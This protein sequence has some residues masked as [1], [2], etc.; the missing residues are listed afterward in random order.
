VD[1]GGLT[2]EEIAERRFSPVGRRGFDKAEV[3]A[4]LAEVAAA[5]RAALDKAEWAEDHVSFERL[6]AEAGALL[7]T[8]KEG[9]ES[10][11]R[12]AEEEAE[13]LRNSARE[14]AQEVR[15]RAKQEAAALVE[16]AT[17]EAER[18]AREAEVVARRLHN[19]TKRQCEQMVV[20]AE[21]RSKR[22]HAHQRA[23][24]NKINDMER[25]FRAFRAEMESS[26]NDGED[27]DLREQVGDSL[28]AVGETDAQ[29]SSGDPKGSGV[30]PKPI[31][32][33]ESVSS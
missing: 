31:F 19:V 33:D 30:Q 25:V 15:S 23:M 6:G 5:Y 26:M 18:I 27:I 9:A 13:T 1:L 21:S 29:D 12:G 10:L 8:A 4:F 11:R 3:A 14:E 24:R 20:D 17:R 32:N 28:S 16:Q 2:P 7:E 22:L